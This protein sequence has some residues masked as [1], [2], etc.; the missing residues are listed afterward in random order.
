M[1]EENIFP[2]DEYGQPFD[3]FFICMLQF[4]AV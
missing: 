4:T 3:L 2:T 1:K